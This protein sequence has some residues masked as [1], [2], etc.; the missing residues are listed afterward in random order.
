M[1]DQKKS[2]FGGQPNASIRWT[3]GSRGND[4]IVFWERIPVRVVT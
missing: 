1:S 2:G 3:S 4:A